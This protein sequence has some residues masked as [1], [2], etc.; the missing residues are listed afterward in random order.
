MSVYKV[1]KAV[2]AQGVEQALAEGYD[3]QAFARA[4]MT[5]VI[6]VYRRARSMD[7][8]ASELKFQADN[9]D[10]DEEYAF[11]RP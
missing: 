10:E 2:M 1:A 11:M 5:E 8:I 3:E 4:M 9:L 6:A 7:D